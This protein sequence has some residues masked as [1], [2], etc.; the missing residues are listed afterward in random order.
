MGSQEIA[1]TNKNRRWYIG[2]AVLSAMI[3]AAVSSTVVK[4]LTP[5]TVDAR[6]TKAL[7]EIKPTLPKKID[8]ITT[9]VDV[10]HVGK[11]VTYLYELDL[12]GRQLPSNFVTVARK[13][14]VPRVC[15][16]S[17]RDGLVNDGVTYVYRYNL[18]GNATV[19]SF[20]VTASDCT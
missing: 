20:T 3:A 6:L 4:G 11:E 17:M 8:Q 1:M 12:G 10:W 9:L 13:A 7:N 2:S 15:G 5:E 14:V 18:P 19:A 16:S